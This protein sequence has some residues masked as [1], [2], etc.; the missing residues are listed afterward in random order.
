M[1][2][3]FTRAK[4]EP[5]ETVL[6]LGPSRGG[7]SDLRDH[8][9]LDEIKR[10]QDSKANIIVKSNRQLLEESSRSLNLDSDISSIMKRRGGTEQQRHKRDPGPMS[11]SRTTPSSGQRVSF[12]EE[13]PS[14]P[15]SALSNCTSYQMTRRSVAPEALER[16]RD[17]KVSMSS[18]YSTTR[19]GDERNSTSSNYSS[20]TYN[21]STY[22]STRIKEERDWLPSS[23]SSRLLVRGDQRSGVE[24]FSHN[25][26]GALS[27]PPKTR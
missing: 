10:T 24:I 21:S 22:S 20:S 18:T 15:S 27:A 12:K 23:S 7:E 3:S 11:M 4:K 26:V 8:S 14:R 1:D 13:S 9:R 17:E 19:R 16:R 2:T 6:Y 25:T 5:R